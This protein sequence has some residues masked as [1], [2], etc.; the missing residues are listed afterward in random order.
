MKK[1]P[2]GI[3]TFEKIITED[4]TYVDKTKEIYD[5]VTTGN[6]FFISRPRRFGKSLLCSTLVSLFQGK[7]ELFKGL[8]IEKSDWKWQPHPV[9]HIELSDLPKDNVTDFKIGL[10]D[11]I[12]DLAYRSGIDT[13]TVNFAGPKLRYLIMELAKQQHVI[14]IID[15]YDDP[16][17][18]NIDKPDTA[19]DIREILRDF[20]KVLK[21]LD[22]YLK[23][24][25]ITGVSKFSKTS[26]FS[27][28]NNLEDMTLDKRY[29]S[30][31]GYT[32]EEIKKSFADR[33]E[34]T[35]QQQAL[36][37]ESLM[38]KITY[39]YDG[40]KFHQDAIQIYN[41][42]S[43]LNY[44]S[45]KELKNYWFETGTPSFL[46]K[47]LEKKSYPPQLFD[48][49]SANGAELGSFD[50]DYL[51]L[52]TILF[53]TGYLTITGFDETFRHYILNFPNE[54]VRY[55]FLT[56]LTSHMTH[57][58][59]SH[60]DTYSYRFAQAL[61]THDLKEFFRLM[62]S[63]LAGVPYTIQVAAEKYYQSLFFTILK[64][65]GASVVA[66]DPTTIGRIDTIYQTDKHMYIIEFKINDTPE[67]AIKQIEEKRY[68]EKFL[69]SGK[70]IVLLGINFDTNKKNL[71]PE[72][73]IKVL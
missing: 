14:I 62:R 31:A 2:I 69:D 53:Q 39:W 49:V 19:N 73:I 63:F 32:K 3:Q 15:E 40:Y 71:D 21:K 26:I 12:D 72:P 5:L 46:I 10:A 8:W 13:R 58:Q 1:L 23:F 51:P 64:L 29:A 18:S 60:I 57:Y 35:A 61:I 34:L 24:V 68:F 56:H 30:I 11:L 54:E 27:G 7:K 4:Y 50:V 6:Y 17:V 55:S 33:L 28:L 22:Q 41:P 45:K 16:L 42:F 20:Y 65:V 44:F 52:K 43:V 48:N 70:Q 25:F 66:E 47:L 36:S 9:I 59:Q 67:N 37:V 38:Q